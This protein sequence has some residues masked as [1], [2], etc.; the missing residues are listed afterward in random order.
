M[1]HLVITRAELLALDDTPICVKFTRLADGALRA[2]LQDAD[3]A[4]GLVPDQHPERNPT[5]TRD[6]AIALARTAAHLSLPTVVALPDAKDRLLAIGGQVDRDLNATTEW[7]NRL[8][9]EPWVIEAIRMAA[10]AEPPREAS[11]EPVAAEADA[12]R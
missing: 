1:K 5:M 6:Q 11:A 8:V 3:S 12:S 4:F 10:A 2:D 7:V 9:I